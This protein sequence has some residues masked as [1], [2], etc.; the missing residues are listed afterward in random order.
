M[1]AKRCSAKIL[2]EKFHKIHR[3]IPVL[4]SLSNTVKCFQAVRLATLLKRDPALV[5]Q[6]QPFVDPLQN[7]SS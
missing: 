7:M 4:E 5:F 2:S 1:V 3:E 6:E